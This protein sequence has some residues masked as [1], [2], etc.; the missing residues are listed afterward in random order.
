MVLGPYD[1]V[2]HMPHSFDNSIWLPAEIDRVFAFFGDALNL[3]SI[4]PT[5]LDFQ[6]LTPPP[7]EMRAGTLLD[8]RIK[9]HGIPIRWRTKITCWQPPTK[10]VDEQ[11]KGPYR[12]WIHTHTFEPKDGGTQI[13]DHV[14]Y[15]HWGTWVMEKLL[16]RRDIE[17]IFAYRE[18]RIRELLAGNAR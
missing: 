18:K 4:T 13:T 6:I 7:I 12:Q 15:S 9:L 16:V 5:F 11:I 10:F 14:V 3:Q 17:T 1:S 8:Y 2:T